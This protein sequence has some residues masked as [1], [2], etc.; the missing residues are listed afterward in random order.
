MTPS[1]ERKDTTTLADIGSDG[2]HETTRQAVR[3]IERRRALQRLIGS[4]ALGGIAA[5]RIFTFEHVH[6]GEVEW[7]LITWIGLALL[8]FGL[9]SW[10]QIVKAVRR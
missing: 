3:K 5:W 10:D 6:E 2:F 7:M 4:Y 9:A 1:H 8:S